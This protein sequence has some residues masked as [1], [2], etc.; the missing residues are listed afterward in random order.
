MV[1]LD[2]EYFVGNFV[3]FLH[4]SISQQLTEIFQVLSLLKSTSNRKFLLL[5]FNLVAI[6]VSDWDMFPTIFLL[7]CLSC[8]HLLNWLLRYVLIGRLL[9]CDLTL[10]HVLD[11]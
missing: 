6:V 8:E 4:L 3:E 10:Q 1:P 5:F 11:G 2:S 7:F 9:D